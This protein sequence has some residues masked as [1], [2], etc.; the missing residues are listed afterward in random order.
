MPQQGR[1]MAKHK[2]TAAPTPNPMLPK[3]FNL[4]LSAEAYK[5]IED[6]SK[7]MGGRSK[8][9]VFRLALSILKTIYPAILRGEDL[10]LL[11]SEGEGKDK[12]VVETRVVIVMK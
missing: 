2:T 8:S 3:R 9:E 4:D 10:A 5:D 6:L 1:K 7:M 11:R 12:K